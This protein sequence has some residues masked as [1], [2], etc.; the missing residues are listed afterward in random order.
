VSEDHNPYLPPR[1]RVDESEAP[2]TLERAG[3]GRRFGTFIIDYIVTNALVFAATFMLV[4]FIGPR[5]AE[6]FAG[7]RFRLF[8]VV[9]L[10]IGYYG[11]F[12][13][14]W[15]RTPG[16]WVCGTMVVSEAGTP[17][18]FRAVIIRTLC[19]YIP[20]EPFSFFGKV[21]SGWHDTI[22]KTQVVLTR[23]R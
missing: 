18:T 22:S 23:S 17:P 10:A 12:E 6:W 3:R 2:R 9:L 1:A 21:G 20:F 13:G 5:A 16:K 7:L 4:L 14:L 15:A 19:R 8:F 11:F